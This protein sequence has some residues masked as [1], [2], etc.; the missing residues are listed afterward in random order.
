MKNIIL[1]TALVVLAAIQST[2]QTKQNIQ[3]ESHSRQLRFP[4]KDSLPISET[5]KTTFTLSR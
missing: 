3:F 5:V 2:G 4:E 1:I